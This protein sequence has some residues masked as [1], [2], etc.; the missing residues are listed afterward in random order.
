MDKLYGNTGVVVVFHQVGQ[1]HDFLIPVEYNIQICNVIM[2]LNTLVQNSKLD[3]TNSTIVCLPINECNCF[4]CSSHKVQMRC[5][6]TSHTLGLCVDG[7]QVSRS[8]TDMFA[9]L[10]I[11]RDY[12]PSFPARSQYSG[13]S[14]YLTSKSNNF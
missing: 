1:I 7:N 14:L 6:K 13:T 11:E 9:L 5:L 2:L 12:T 8:I 4:L 3:G 10:R